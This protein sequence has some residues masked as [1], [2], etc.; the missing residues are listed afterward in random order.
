MSAFCRDYVMKMGVCAEG[1]HID[2][3]LLPQEL[4]CT[5]HT[6]ILPLFHSMY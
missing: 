4:G 2:I 5:S 6:V 1:A 3:G